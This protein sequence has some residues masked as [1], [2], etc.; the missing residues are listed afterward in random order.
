MAAPI[1][2]ERYVE[3]TRAPSIMTRSDDDAVT[4]DDAIRTRRYRSAGTSC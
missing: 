3:C 1:L 2:L 4:Y